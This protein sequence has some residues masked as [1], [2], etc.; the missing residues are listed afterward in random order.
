M[1][2]VREVKQLDVLSL[3]INDLQAPFGHEGTAST[4]SGVLVPLGVS[5]LA[6]AY[7]LACM[8]GLFL[9]IHLL[10]PGRSA[11]CPATSLGTPVY[12]CTTHATNIMQ[13][14]MHV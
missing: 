6:P 1:K 8:L 7:M 13:V 12:N 9:V 11:V 10:F 14:E 4:H 3:P 5:V 2:V